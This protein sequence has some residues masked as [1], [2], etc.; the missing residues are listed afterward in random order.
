MVAEVREALA[1]LKTDFPG[2]AGQGYELAGFVWYQGWNDGVDPK[3]AVPE[4][5]Q[6]LVNLI[7]DVRKEFKAPK[8]PVVVGELTG[9]WVDAP[10]AWATLRTAQAGAAARPEFKGN[11]LFVPTR[12][13][14]RPAKESP[15]PT[16]GHHEFGNAETYVLVGDALGKGMVK[17]LTQPKEKPEPAKQP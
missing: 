2:Y 8:L 17:L 15:N 16:H 10:G 11:V 7:N 3:K 1:N 6:N 13:F 4:Y 9:P 12:D 5:E 14:V